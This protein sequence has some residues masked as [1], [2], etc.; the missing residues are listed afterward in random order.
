MN[1]LPFISP[2]TF[3]LSG[4]VS[5]SLVVLINSIYVFIIGFDR[6]IDGIDQLINALLGYLMALRD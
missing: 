2:I 5:L 3:G 4:K 6:W 1:G